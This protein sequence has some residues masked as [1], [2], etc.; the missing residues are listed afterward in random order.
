MTISKANTKHKTR[1]FIDFEAITNPFAKI[2]KIENSTPYCYTLGFQAEHG[3]FKSR[4]YVMNFKNKKNFY[5][6]LRL[7]IKKDIKKINPKIKIQDVEFVGHNPVLE[8]K[9]LKRLFPK[10]KVIPLIS[11]QTISLSILTRKQFKKQYFSEIKEIIRQKSKHNVFKNRILSNNGAIASYVGFLLFCKENN[12]ET[13]KHYYT[14]INKQL[15][16]KELKEYSHDDVWK[17]EYVN[18]HLEEVDMWL[19]DINHRRELIKQLN[20]LELDENMTIKE[21][22]DRIWDI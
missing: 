17:M 19:K 1:V 3:I 5:E 4:T 7:Q 9:C 22:K 6:T 18:K 11:Q 2:I 16:V 15:L 20:A 13:T 12:F 21:L 8:N 10:N 14:E